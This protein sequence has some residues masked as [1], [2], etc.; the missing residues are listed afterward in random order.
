MAHTVSVG[1][2]GLDSSHKAGDFFELRGN[3]GVIY[4]LVYI[5]YRY[6]GASCW[7]VWLRLN[8]GEV[9]D[10]ARKSEDL[11]RRAGDQLRFIGRDL[12]ITI[13]TPEGS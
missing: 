6:P 11:I 12:Q 1:V 5:K 7:W 2:A 13:S 3:P 9:V 10:M 8:S 4:Q